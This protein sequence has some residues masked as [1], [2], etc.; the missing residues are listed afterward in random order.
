M[1]K[2]EHT[3]QADFMVVDLDNWQDRLRELRKASKVAH[4]T[5]CLAIQGKMVTWSISVCS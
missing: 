3:L 1:S 5:P 2:A 4:V